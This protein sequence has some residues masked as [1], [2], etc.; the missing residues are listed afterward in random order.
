MR[1]EYRVGDV[2]VR[3]N[4]KESSQGQP[5]AIFELSLILMLHAMERTLSLVGMYTAI[6]HFTVKSLRI[7]LIILF[8][9]TR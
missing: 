1:G 5:E 9:G 4:Q 3:S 7:Y 6:G 2:E 8:P